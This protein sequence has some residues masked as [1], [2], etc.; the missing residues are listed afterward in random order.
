GDELRAHLSDQLDAALQRLEVGDGRAGA[1]D[2]DGMRVERDHAA[3]EPS[4]LALVQH[5]ANEHAVSAVYAI[6]HP[7]GEGVFSGRRAA[8]QFVT[9]EEHEERILSDGLR[10]ILTPAFRRALRRYTP[11]K[12]SSS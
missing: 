12:S 6:E 1:E 11:V 2:G 9:N 7:D 8:T 3:G 5:A 10:S 4:G